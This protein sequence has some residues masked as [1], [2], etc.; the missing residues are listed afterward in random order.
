MAD[1]SDFKI[2][3]SRL[4]AILEPYAPRMVVKEDSDPT[5]YLDTRRMQKTHAGQELFQLHC[6]E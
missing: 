4:K 1:P 3:F 6:H 2:I 5:Y